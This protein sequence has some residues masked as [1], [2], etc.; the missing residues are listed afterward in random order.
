MGKLVGRVALI[1]GAGYGIGRAS[2]LLF[3][4]EGARLA[5]VDFAPD[6]GHRTVDIIREEGGDA[7]FVEADI[8]VEADVRTMVKA[9]VDTFGRIDI[10]FNNAGI[11]RF[12]S[13]AGTTEEEWDLI[14]DTNL[15]GVFLC[16]KHTIPLMLAQGRG[17]IINTSSGA[18]LVGSPGMAA[19]CASKA[20]VILLTKTTALEYARHNIRVNCICPGVVQTEMSDA[21]L[22]DLSARQAFAQSVPLGRIGQP[23]EIAQLALYLA[24]D[25]SSYVTGAAFS[26]D[27]G[28]TAGVA[29]PRV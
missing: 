11:M 14:L 2:A 7:A 3:A 27:G 4:R 9:I 21:L 29:L 19:Y 12:G 13:T 24:C 23:C 26:I 20:G 28:G 6:G 1:T 15:K 17:V 16:S 10:L 8:S 5:V 25:D 18:G 22:A